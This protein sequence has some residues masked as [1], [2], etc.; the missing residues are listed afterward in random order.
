MIGVK[1]EDKSGEEKKEEFKMKIGRLTKI[2][3]RL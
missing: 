2:D 1:E 3:K